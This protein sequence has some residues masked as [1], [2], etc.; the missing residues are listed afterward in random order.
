MVVRRNHPRFTHVSGPAP[1]VLEA[2]DTV[3]DVIPPPLLLTIFSGH[4]VVY[5]FVRFTI[6]YIDGDVRKLNFPG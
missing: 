5:S 2:K 4:C 1:F 6:I 3:C